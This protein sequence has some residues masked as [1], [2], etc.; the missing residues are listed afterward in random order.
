MKPAR[1][2]SIKELLTQPVQDQAHTEKKIL[3]PI[4]DLLRRGNISSP[5]L[6]YTEVLSPR[7]PRCGMFDEAK[8]KELE[9]L[10]KRGT[11][12][13]MFRSELEDDPNIVPSR[14]VL[15]IKHLDTGEEV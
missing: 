4:R 11:F 7:D 1:L 8:R 5:T 3:T 10:F 14:F 2:P 12:K 15:T 9:G 6:Y 13:M